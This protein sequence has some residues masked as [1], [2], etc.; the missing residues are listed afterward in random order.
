MACKFR[1]NLA[2]DQQMNKKSCEI[3]NYLHCNCRVGVGNRLRCFPPRNRRR[4]PHRKTGRNRKTVG[5]TTCWAVWSAVFVA[6]HG[7]PSC[8]VCVPEKERQLAHKNHQK[9]HP[10][11]AKTTKTKR[12][13]WAKHPLLVLSFFCKNLLFF[14]LYLAKCLLCF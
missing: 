11:V 1:Q 2:K 10:V 14:Q 6:W 8:G 4:I 3:G 13:P 7:K 5:H 12:E 9:R